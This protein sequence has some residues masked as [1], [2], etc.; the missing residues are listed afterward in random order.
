M[1]PGPCP[2]L[3]VY[4]RYT[5]IVQEPVQGTGLAQKETISPGTTLSLS[6]TSVNISVSAV[7]KYH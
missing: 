7:R 1:G 4:S 3:M 6:Q 2:C 5:G